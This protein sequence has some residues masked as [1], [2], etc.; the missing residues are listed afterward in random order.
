MQI[1]LVRHAG[2]VDELGLLWLLS[3]VVRVLEV[4]L[5]TLVPVVVWA[6]AVVRIASATEK[7]GLTIL[8]AVRKLTVVVIITIWNIDSLFVDKLDGLDDWVAAG[9]AHGEITGCCVR[10]LL[11]LL[12]LGQVRG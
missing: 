12:L 6:G 2:A 7:L 9:R 5:A 8:S 10:W 4:L 11:L 3:I 1:E